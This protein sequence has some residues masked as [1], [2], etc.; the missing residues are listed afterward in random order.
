MAAEEN[1]LGRT[2]ALLAV[3]GLGEEQ[4]QRGDEVAQGFEIVKGRAAL[5]DSAA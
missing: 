4:V 2:G 5:I 3:E 1:I